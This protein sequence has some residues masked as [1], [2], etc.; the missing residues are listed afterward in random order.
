MPRALIA[1]VLLGLLLA[2]CAE[3]GADRF[4]RETCIGCHRELNPGLVDQLLASPHE[5][6]P[7]TCE[8][9]HGADHEAIFATKGAVPP[10]VCAE[11]HEEAYAEFRKSRHGRHLK[12]GKA[13]PLL[14]EQS[15][16]AGSCSTGTGCHSIQHAY[17]DGSVGRC[18]TCHPAHS[19]LNRDARNPRICI[20]CHE[21]TDHPQHRAWLRSS[22]SMASPD[23][24]GHVADCVTCH[25]THD[26]SDAVTHGLSPFLKEEPALSVPVVPAEE[27]TA[28]R[29]TMLGRCRS[30]H[31][32]RFARQALEL[33][34]LWRYRGA[35]YLD[36]AQRL[37]K[38]MA[39]E[40]RLE[41]GFD[42]RLPNPAT[43]HAFDLGGPQVFD[44]SR[45]VPE[46]IYYEMFFH[47]YPELF[48]A[49]YHTDPERI[50][51]E[52]N[53]KLKT[54]LDEL[55]EYRRQEPRPRK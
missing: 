3:E 42:F 6:V 26:V 37:M 11:C 8:E 13:D 20:G 25:G 45:S 44:L 31:G 4:A 17:P 19:F 2:A 29:E 35:L 33:A 40:G 22:H 55:R 1:A 53:D 39:N 49:A 54:A 32:T 41:P 12:E 23:G 9:C 50:A 43:G 51:W 30:C 27:F 38:E 5:K 14:F 46:R 47:L 7:V 21:G 10:T 36:E 28:K 16:A 34:D 18:S 52:S 15:F 48:R 24:E